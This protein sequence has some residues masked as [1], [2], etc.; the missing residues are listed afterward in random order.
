MFLVLEKNSWSNILLFRLHITHYRN[1]GSICRD[2]H[3]TVQ[4]SKETPT[5]YLCDTRLLCKIH[6][7][8]V[9]L[10]VG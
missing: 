3:H 6:V 8:M 5:V 4:G 9:M 10:C 1:E 7:C 2:R